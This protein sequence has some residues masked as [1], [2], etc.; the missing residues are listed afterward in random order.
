LVG[1]GGFESIVVVGPV[2]AA[3]TIALALLRGCGVASK[4]SVALSLPS[5]AASS[6][7]GQL[8]SIVRRSASPSGMPSGS[9]GEPEAE[10]VEPAKPPQETQSSEPAQQAAPPA[11]SIANPVSAR[12]GAT[13]KAAC[14]PLSPIRIVCWPAPLGTPEAKVKVPLTEPPAP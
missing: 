4:K 5:S 12:S 11:G 2:Q 1:F 6:R 10:G 7:V 8:G 13:P 9:A 3:S 14:T